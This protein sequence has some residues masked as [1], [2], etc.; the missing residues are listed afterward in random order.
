MGAQ[1]GRGVGEQE[2]RGAALVWF[3]YRPCALHVST[4]IN[5][6]IN[7]MIH[8]QALQGRMDARTVV[9]VHDGGVDAAERHG[10]LGH[11]NG[12]G[13]PPPGRAPVVLRPR[14]GQ[15]GG[16]GEGWRV[17]MRGVGGGGVLPRRRLPALPQARP[18]PGAH[19]G[20]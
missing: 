14:V 16:R 18:K 15:E 9:R 6:M 12:V 5:G 8:R 2:G 19:R 11:G 3:A 10:H 1:E 20:R 17:R 4:C 13:R 7:G